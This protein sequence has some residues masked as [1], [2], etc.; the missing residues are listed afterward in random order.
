MSAGGRRRAPPL[1]STVIYFARPLAVQSATARAET[2][3]RT[4]RALRSAAE[5]SRR[6]IRAVQA[7]SPSPSSSRA[8]A[9]YGV[10][11]AGGRK[12]SSAAS[13]RPPPEGLEYAAVGA[14]PEVSTSP[15]GA[16]APAF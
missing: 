11:P 16:P 5:M 7:R 9:R 4:R 15:R 10:A 1:V 14:P 2:C 8:P 3:A 13:L 6:G 12:A